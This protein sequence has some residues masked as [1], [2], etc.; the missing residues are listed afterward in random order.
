M[1]PEI[2][3]PLRVRGLVPAVARNPYYAGFSW[4]DP[5][6]DHLVHLLRHVYE[7]RDEARAVGARAA[8]TVAREWTWDR[9]ARQIIARLATIGEGRL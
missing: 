6:F 1:R 3:Y 5:D 2:S 8:E 7:Q 9:A 4:A